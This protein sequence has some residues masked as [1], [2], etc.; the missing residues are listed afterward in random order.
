MYKHG[1][2]GVRKPLK[3]RPQRGRATE[4]TNPDHS[5]PLSQLKTPF[6]SVLVFN[7]P[8]NDEGNRARGH[9]AKAES[10]TAE[11]SSAA[12]VELHGWSQSSTR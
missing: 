3:R 1:S 10:I 11:P 4:K 6:G 7:L 9:V 5:F 12:A 2:L 8:V